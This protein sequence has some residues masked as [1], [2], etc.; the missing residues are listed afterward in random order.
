M[1]FS[2]LARDPLSG[3]I[4]GAAATGSLC[5]GGWVLRGHVSAGMSASQGAAPST[6]WGEEVL[7][8]MHDGA[9]A[10][11]AVEQISAAD[12]GRAYR[13]LTALDLFGQTG[14]FTGASNEPEKG[15]LAFHQGIVAGNLLASTDVLDAMVDR[16]A[17]AEGGLGDRLL[18]SLRAATQMGGDSRG[19][20]SAALL[21][22]HP[23]KPPL[24]LRID[25]DPDNPIAA[26]EHLYGKATTGAYSRW[27]EQVPTPNDRERILD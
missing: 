11:D 23:D 6:I 18:A 7:T 9:S 15:S 5:V 3:A 4:G 13:Q 25:Y 17:E 1:T 8:A 16:F 19:L 20:L 24:S 10:A 27:T 26:L 21:V 12:D 2:I 22:L 14:E